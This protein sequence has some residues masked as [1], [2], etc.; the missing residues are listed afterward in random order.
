[1]FEVFRP[2]LKW[3]ILQNI[4]KHM[5]SSFKRTFPRTR[6]VIDCTEIFIQKP[7]TRTAQRQTYSRGILTINAK[8]I[9]SQFLVVAAFLCNFSKP[10]VKKLIRFLNVWYF[11]IW[12]SL[13]WL[14]NI[15]WKRR[16]R[17]FTYHCFI[18]FNKFLNVQYNNVTVLHIKMNEFDKCISFY[19]VDIK[20]HEYLILVLL[21]NI[22][23]IDKTQYSVP[24]IEFGFNLGS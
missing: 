4:R 8:P 18:I 6:V 7:R 1:M 13:L 2:Q 3:P 10:L 9:A 11:A 15:K 5:P 19:T 20:N 14:L 16:Y 21:V 22:I 24:Y 23:S 12:I 17:A